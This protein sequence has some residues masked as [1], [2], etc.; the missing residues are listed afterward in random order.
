MIVGNAWSRGRAES[1]MDQSA[2][3]FRLLVAL[4]RVICT[5]ILYRFLGVYV[6]VIN[7]GAFFV[8]IFF[9]Y[10]LFMSPRREEEG[11]GEGAPLG[12]FC[13]FPFSEIFIVC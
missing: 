1:R 10:S 5:N 13:A 4:V 9:S 3:D 8:F 7:C 11:G 12:E 2:A 6:F